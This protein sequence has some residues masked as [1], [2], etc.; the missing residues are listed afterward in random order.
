MPISKTS[1]SGIILRSVICREQYSTSGPG[2]KYTASPRLTEPTFSEA[3]S[4]PG[5]ASGAQRSAMDIEET[6]PVEA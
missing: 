6:P 5:Q 3:I 1:N 4:T 2:L